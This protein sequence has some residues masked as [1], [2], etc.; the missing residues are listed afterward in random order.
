M[1]LLCKRYDKIGRRDIKCLDWRAFL[2]TTGGDRNDRH[3]AFVLARMAK[4]DRL[5]VLVAA[6]NDTA[7]G[8][9]LDE[10]AEVIGQDRRTAERLRN[11]IR[12]HFDLEERLDDRRKRFRIR[13]T[14]RRVYTRPNAAELAALEASAEA[15]RR[16]GSPAAPALTSLLA[17]VKGSLDD[18]EK[19]RL[20]PDL[21]PLVALQRT[22]VGPGPSLGPDEQT[23]A[24]IQGAMMGGQCLEFDYVAEGASEPKWRRVI[25]FG[26][27]HG[28]V[29]YL[30]GKIPSSDAP[31]VTFRL[32]RM[33]DARTSSLPGCPPD[34]WDLDQWM[35]GSFGIWRE[36]EHDIVLHVA[37]SASERA[38]SWRFHPRQE[39]EEDD[40][41][42]TV[43]FRSGGLREIAEHL[44]TWGSD[45]RIV[46]PEELRTM[47]KDR[48]LAA[49]SI[50]GNDLQGCERH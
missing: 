28:P 19:R 5:L 42:L 4:L 36:E 8:L 31:P 34:V 48:L 46:S 15:A 21:E 38:R 7:E 41:G 33:H 47:M 13:D 3:G 14:L 22:F 50:V 37:A 11:I 49:Q 29:T 12:E 10:M 30:V 39:L 45:I 6:L 35:A 23:L 18:R 32:D 44:F 27:L 17:K 40:E 25:I 2:T 26:L 9:T 24:V 43:R 20:D 1:T 16:S